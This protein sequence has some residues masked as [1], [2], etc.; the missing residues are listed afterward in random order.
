MKYLPRML[1]CSLVL[2]L[3][4]KQLK[5]SQVLKQYWMMEGLACRIQS[6]HQK[7]IDEKTLHICKLISR[8]LRHKYSRRVAC[9]Q[10]H[11][12]RSGVRSVGQVVLEME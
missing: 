9:P 5:R 1:H 8:A 11:L 3:E 7:I 4:L 6:Y 10:V 12:D 2:P